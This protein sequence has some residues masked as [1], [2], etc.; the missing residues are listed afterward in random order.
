MKT[1]YHYHF[2]NF[3]A[4]VLSLDPSVLVSSKANKLCWSE[5]GACSAPICRSQ[6][7]PARR[8]RWWN[9]SEPLITSEQRN[10]ALSFL[11][12]AD[13]EQPQHTQLMTKTPAKRIR[14]SPL[15][16]WLLCALRGQWGFNDNEIRS[17]HLPA[18]ATRMC[19][20]ASLPP[21]PGPSRRHP[22]SC[23]LEQFLTKFGFSLMNSSKRAAEPGS[24]LGQCVGNRSSLIHMSALIRAD[25]PLL[26]RL[27]H[28]FRLLWQSLISLDLDGSVAENAAPKLPVTADNRPLLPF[29]ASLPATPTP[30]PEPAFLV[31]YLPIFL[32]FVSSLLTYRLSSLVFLHFW[33]MSRTRPDV[34]LGPQRAPLTLITL[35]AVTGQ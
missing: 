4:H 24:F 26:P 16:P 25:A 22:E 27:L 20:A 31:P 30:V 28:A 15:G 10:A 23:S 7:P 1:F 9:R 8:A 14:W 19:T 35:L 17:F 33:I 13:T 3:N 5:R 12:T 11:Q 21:A 18:E 32:L 2:I 6:P 29:W 34:P